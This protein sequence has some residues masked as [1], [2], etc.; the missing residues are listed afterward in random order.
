M[1][2]YHVVICVALAGWCAFMALYWV[3]PHIGMPTDSNEVPLLEPG[4]VRAVFWGRETA[5]NPPLHRMISALFPVQ[6]TIAAGRM[7]SLLCFATAV[8]FAFL[9]GRKLS[10]GSALVG[11]ATAMMLA[12]NWE[13][14]L[15][16]SM[17]RSYGMWLAL[18]MWHWWALVRVL[19]DNNRHARVE[20]A[21][22]AV[23]LPW[24]HYGS[25]PM[26]L[27]EGLGVLAFSKQRWNIF[28]L[29]IPAAVAFLPLL[30]PIFGKTGAD[31][32]PSGRGS[33]EIIKAHSTAG[34]PNH[35]I[36]WLLL[37]PL[38]CVYWLD[39][40]HRVMLL[41]YAGMLAAT[42]VMAQ[43]HMVRAPA[44]LWMAPMLLPLVASLG[45]VARVEPLRMVWAVGII[46][47]ALG[48]GGRHNRVSRAGEGMDFVV[49][50]WSVWQQQAAGR[51]IY[52]KP[53]GDFYW[54]FYELKGRL[55]RSETQSPLCGKRRCFVHDGVIVRPLD[56]KRP[57]T[58]GLVL[59][60][61]CWNL[62]KKHPDGCR[63]LIHT[64]CARASLCE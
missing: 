28:P 41:A 48:V 50:N 26:L 30:W 17:Y 43:V 53:G 4:G 37:V 31:H 54:L 60:I 24:V 59:E 64:H 7:I 16:S 33:W 61:N 38:V 62:P 8:V 12:C 27:F 52:V 5:I 29:F 6:D 45:L 42:G 3:G 40:A 1:R 35:R 19:D 34:L 20:L 14:Q 21:V 10:R 11:A 56:D 39:S 46:V 32:I 9:L 47:I 44:A 36:P 18:A 25:V 57:S 2:K 49:N 55:H 15:Q 23:L 63:L 51:D 22:S 58:P 13:A